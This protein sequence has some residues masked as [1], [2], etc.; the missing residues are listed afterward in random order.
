M[1]KVKSIKVSFVLEGNGVIN[2]EG[3]PDFN[4]KN[5]L[6]KCGRLSSDSKQYDNA[7]FAK[8]NYYKTGED[9]VKDE[10]KISSYCFNRLLIEDVFPSMNPVYFTNND[11]FTKFTG[12]PEGFSQGWMA[13]RLHGSPKHSQFM[14]KIDLVNI[15]EGITQ[16]ETCSTSAPKEETSSTDDS[17]NNFFKKETIGKTEYKGEVCFDLKQTFLCTS[18]NAD[19]ALN[20]TH[21][22]DFMKNLSKNTTTVVTKPKWYKELSDENTDTI[23]IGLEGILLSQE[24]VKYIIT[25]MCSK[26]FRF[27]KQKAHANLCYKPN[28]MV[29][30]FFMGF[31]EY[32]N[33]IE[34]SAIIKNTSQIKQLLEQCELFLPWRMLTEEEINKEIENKIPTTKPPKENKTKKTKKTDTENSNTEENQTEEGV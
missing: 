27:N 9:T 28:S 32:G 1:D 30:T 23:S 26:I 29:I 3:Q 21:I 34:N 24:T 8:R 22:D 7:T 5:L 11:M 18:G 4:Q 20:N 25:H 33:R 16:L 15:G 17:A 19:I 10:L 2:Y 12:T 6:Y 13:P 31:D 14:K